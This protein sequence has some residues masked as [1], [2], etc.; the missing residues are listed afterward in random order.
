[1]DVCLELFP[2]LQEVFP[3]VEMVCLYG[4]STDVYNGER[5][6]V[7]TTHQL[8]RF[9]E[10]FDV[11]FIDEV[12]AFPYAKDPFLEYAVQK[13]Q[14]R[15][16]CSIFITATPDRKWQKEC[17]SGKRHFVKI[18]ARYHRKSL[19]VPRKVWIGDWKK[20][21]QKQKNS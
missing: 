16:G 2:R 21:L 8:V 4:D 20:R 7:A 5:F 15:T 11:I 18:P 1:M 17:N 6:V 19:P 10:A 14:L 3:D 13:A 9:Y 12:D